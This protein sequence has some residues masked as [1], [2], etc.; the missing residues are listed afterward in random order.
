MEGCTKDRMDSN[1]REV[2]LCEGAE[3]MEFYPRTDD[4]PAERLWVRIRG[5]TA[6]V[7]L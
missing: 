5:Q 7:M 6:Q 2:G 4:E 3:W 1:S